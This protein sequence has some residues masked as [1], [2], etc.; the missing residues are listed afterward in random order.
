M[1]STVLSAVLQG[2]QV[3]FVHVEADTS[4]GL[5][6]FHMVGYLS[7]EV[8]E[9]GERVKTA[10]RNAGFSMPAKKIVVNLSPANVRKRGASFDL[11]I[12]V[13]ILASLSAIEGSALG[14]TVI[15][16]ELSLDGS[17]RRVS[18]VLPIVAEAKK[19][20][21]QT[22]IIPKANAKEGALVEGMNV[23]GVADLSEVCAILNQTWKASPK[24]AQE[25]APLPEHE[26]Y[27]EDFREIQGQMVVK[28]AAEVAVAGGHNL[29]F[30]GPPGSGKTM[31]AKRIPTILPPLTAKE[32][33]ELTKIYSVAGLLEKE[34]PLMTQRPFRSVH[35][36]ITKA[37]LVG[38][39][40]TP[41]FGEASLSNFGI[42]FL[43]ELAEFQKPVL[44]ALRQPLEER[45]IRIVRNRGAYVFPADFMLVA[46]MNPCPCGYYPDYNRCICSA[47][48][49][50]TYLG[51]IS[52]PFLSRIDICIEASKVEY[53]SLRAT[54][55]PESSS[56]IQK[57]VCK[58]REIQKQRYEDIGINT[59][60]QL[61]VTELE[62]YCTLDEKTEAFMKQAYKKMGMTARIY[63]KVLRVARTVAD[64]DGQE[65]I[66]LRH[67]KEA[68]SYR[69]IDQKYWG[70][71]KQG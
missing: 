19:Q 51:K 36:T 18:G 55:K 49:I 41:V 35:H 17:V 50:H 65:Q 16:G 7:S 39:G 5:P 3:E 1:F 20:G 52:Q 15:V 10:I 31:I 70:N 12:A 11:P 61:G 34:Q 57:R 23:Y 64:L 53:E 46:A 21:F 6:M 56:E 9:A 29:L 43:D 13:A 37:G 33:M 69:T 32:S 47:N 44:E 28:R 63:H 26:N 45:E 2:L 60:S 42:L 66:S 27:K 24:C 30:I 38:G 22:C 58:A 67:L 59:N 48:Q 25:T 8:K 68:V 71:E 4:N 40:R 14:D 62:R 54:E